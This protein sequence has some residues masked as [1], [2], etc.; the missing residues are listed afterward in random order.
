MMTQTDVARLAQLLAVRQAQW[1]VTAAQQGVDEA[2]EQIEELKAQ[3]QRATQAWIRAKQALAKEE[4]RLRHLEQS[5][6]ERGQGTR[7]HVFAEIKTPPLHLIRPVSTP[8]P[9]APASPRRQP[10]F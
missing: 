6:E 9:A 7:Q 8:L 3:L 4:R 10:F 1:N 5:Q 2:R